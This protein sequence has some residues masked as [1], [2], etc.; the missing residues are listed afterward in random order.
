M[1]CDI[2]WRVP[3]RQSPINLVYNF[4]FPGTMFK[5]KICGCNLIK[6]NFRSDVKYLRIFEIF[7]LRKNSFE[8]LILKFGCA[9]LNEILKA[10]FAVNMVMKK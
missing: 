7:H 2:S 6:L 3:N 4:I 10:V 1:S 8:K 9:M 5:I